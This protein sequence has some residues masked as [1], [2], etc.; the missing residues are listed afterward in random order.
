[1]QFGRW[2]KAAAACL[3]YAQHLPVARGSGASV[4]P[5]PPLI[6]DV[7]N[8]LA[9]GDVHGFARGLETFFNGLA[10]E[11]LI[12]EACFRAVLQTPLSCF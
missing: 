10:H 8:R 5:R 2:L 3:R 1:M 11:N 6:D 7:H 12:N 9:V 4:Q